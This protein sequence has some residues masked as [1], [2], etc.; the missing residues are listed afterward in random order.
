M[1]LKDWRKINRQQQNRYLQ[2]ARE[3]QLGII[4]DYEF[5]LL[6]REV[7]ETMDYLERL[8]QKHIYLTGRRYVGQ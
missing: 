8:Q 7:Q 2:S 6:Q 1:M 5:S 3:S 4:D